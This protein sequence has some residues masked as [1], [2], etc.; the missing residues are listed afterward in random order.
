MLLAAGG[1]VAV[2]AL[3]LA[4]IQVG[5]A[6]VA[7]V[8]DQGIGPLTGVGL[9][10]V[11]HP[12]RHD[13]LVLAFDG[14]IGGVAQNPPI[15][16]FEDVTDGIRKTALRGGFGLACRIGW[17]RALRHCQWICLPLGSKVQTRNFCPVDRQLLGVSAR[18]RA[19]RAQ[20]T[21]SLAALL[22]TN[23]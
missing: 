11:A 13:H 3:V 5:G 4:G 9:D 6:A 10:A 12:D 7:G 18:L 23:C 2:E 20:R 1:D 22:I 16:A 17:E 19:P 14:C 15:T 8:R 21:V